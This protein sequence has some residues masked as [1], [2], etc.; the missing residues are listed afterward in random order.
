M[1]ANCF[2]KS[3]NFTMA[4]SIEN[5]RQRRLIE[6]DANNEIGMGLDMDPS[7]KRTYYQ[8]EY[9]DFPG[10]TKVNGSNHVS[11]YWE[12]GQYTSKYANVTVALQPHRNPSKNGIKLLFFVADQKTKEPIKVGFLL[13]INSPEPGTGTSKFLGMFLDPSLRGGGLSKICLAI[14][15]HFCL[16]AKIKPVTGIMNKPLLCL[17]LQH[18]FGWVP[19]DKRQGVD[20]EISTGDGGSVVLYSSRTRSLLG[21][22]SPSDLK[23]QNIVLSQVPPDPRGRT[24]RIRAALEPPKDD[25]DEFQRLVNHILFDTNGEADFTYEISSRDIR[26]AMLG[27]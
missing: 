12:I 15:M 22:F 17:V 1:I 7:S 26:R 19:I 5:R 13:M 9:W 6:H 20:A 3:G 18:K 11:N 24:T 16:E 23:H 2:G 4:K 21:A 10:L 25:Y 8:F 14:W 27:Q